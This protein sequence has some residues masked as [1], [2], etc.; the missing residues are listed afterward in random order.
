MAFLGTLK[1]NVSKMQDDFNKSRQETARSGRTARAATLSA[2]KADVS[3][4][5]ENARGELDTVRR[6]FSGMVTEARTNR[7][8]F[9]DGLKKSVAILRKS[10]LDDLTGAREA[11]FAV[12]RETVHI[13]LAGFREERRA[14]D[15]P[16]VEPAPSTA[17]KAQRH[18]EPV[19]EFPSLGEPVDRHAAKTEEEHPEAGV[20]EEVRETSEARSKEEKKASRRERNR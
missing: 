18:G 20:Q 10:S 15:L 4:L 7:S 19:E 9:V 1:T 8:E 5:M 16:A 2:I 11:W 12:P 3:N 6:L 13:S 14:A 17:E